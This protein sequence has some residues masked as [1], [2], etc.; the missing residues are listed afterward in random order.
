MLDRSGYFNFVVKVLYSLI[1]RVKEKHKEAVLMYS[2]VEVVFNFVAKVHY[3][4]ILSLCFF[5]HSDPLEC[6]CGRLHVFINM[7][8]LQGK[9]KDF[10]A[11]CVRCLKDLVSGNRQLFNTEDFLSHNKNF[12]LIL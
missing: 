12:F 1:T 11:F 3:I 4:P 8:L 7:L 2:Y 6:N 10:F 5:G 9:K